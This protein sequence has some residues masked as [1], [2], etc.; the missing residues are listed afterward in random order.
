V[1]A[2]DYKCH[3]INTF[4]KIEP[5]C[6]RV[7]IFYI[8]NNTHLTSSLKLLKYCLNHRSFK[9]L[10]QHVRVTRRATT[11]RVDCVVWTFYDKRST[12][13]PGDLLRS[14]PR[15]VGIQWG[16]PESVHTVSSFRTVRSGRRDSR[17]YFLITSWR[18][19][20]WRSIC[21]KYTTFTLHRIKICLQNKRI[22]VVG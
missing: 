1:F 4:M 20:P 7:L 18:N 17:K 3:S 19:S 6:C 8:H 11:N 2:T 10:Y 21:Q 22:W 9:L 16:L 14:S 5:L 13:S 12:K 15:L